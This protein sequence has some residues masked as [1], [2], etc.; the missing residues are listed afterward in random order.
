MSGFDIF[1]LLK[2]PLK[3]KCHSLGCSDLFNY[4]FCTEVLCSL[5][6]SHV[7][8]NFHDSLLQIKHVKASV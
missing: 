3:K 4:K 5:T 6:T 2:L 7:V 1:F 8:G